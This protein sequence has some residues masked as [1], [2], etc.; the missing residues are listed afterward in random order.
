M[1]EGEAKKLLEK[2]I[3]LHYNMSCN[4]TL[5]ECEDETHTLEMGTWESS[6]TPESLEFDC[7]G[8]NTSHWGV[9]YIIGKLLKCRCP[10]WARMNHL[11]IR[12]TSYGQKKGW[13]SNWQFDS[14]PWK[15]AQVACNMPSENS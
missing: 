10:K 14:R 15:V 13:E 7:K 4:P 3:R 12:N 5:K 11:D 6:G 1:L 8:K 9:L 2:L